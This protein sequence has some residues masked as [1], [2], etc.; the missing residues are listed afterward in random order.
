MYSYVLVA[1]LD[2]SPSLMEVTPGHRPTSRLDMNLC[3]L[4][5]CRSSPFPLL[6]PL[7][8]F[9]FLPAISFHPHYCRCYCHLLLHLLLLLFSSTHVRLF[10]FLF[11]S[12]L[13]LLIPSITYRS[14]LIRSSKYREKR[15]K[16][17]H[18]FILRK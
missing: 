10:V 15:K 17:F 8:A 18:N 9:V 16:D 4:S 3:L 1:T 14:L 11:L 13:L 6:S 7:P 2:G 12:I 5:T